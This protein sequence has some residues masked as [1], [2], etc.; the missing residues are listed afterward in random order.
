MME[1][2]EDVHLEN[3]L[4]SGRNHKGNL[5]GIQ[6]QRYDPDAPYP[7]LVK[8]VAHMAFDVEDLQS[9]LVGQ[10]V[11]VQP[12]SPV[13]GLVVAFIEVDGLLLNR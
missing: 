11:I 10:K 7:D 4:P 9:V 5:F 12:N 3:A 2:E 6:W 8:A 13:E 1:F